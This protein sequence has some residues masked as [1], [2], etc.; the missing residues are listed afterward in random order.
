[1]DTKEKFRCEIPSNKWVHEETEKCDF[2]TT[3]YSAYRV[4]KE[5]LKRDITKREKVCK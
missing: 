4:C 2:G 1:M 3:S 5:A